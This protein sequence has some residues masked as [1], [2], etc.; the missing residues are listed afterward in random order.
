[1][2]CAACATGEEPHTVALLLAAR[3]M[4]GDVDVVASDISTQAL[5]RARTGRFRGRA[6]RQ[7]L[8][9]YAAPW[10]D[11][12]ERGV[13][14]S[15]RLTQAIDWR[16]VN[17]VDGAAVAA[18]GVF[19]IVLCRNVLIY[20]SDETARR[21]IDALGAALVPGGALFVGVS[22]SLLRLGTAL[23]CEEHQGVFLYKKAI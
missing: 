5:A 18:L 1:M 7:S 2:W 14:A 11:V 17:L 4:L 9:E 23:I 10:L 6:L 15:P 13:T 16:Q 22:E 20:F 8:P 21:V 3:G 19:D 12:D